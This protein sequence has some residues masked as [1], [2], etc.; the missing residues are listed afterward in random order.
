[1]KINIEKAMYRDEEEPLDENCKCSVCKNYS[2]AFIHHLY[3]T[4][5]PIKERYGSIHNLYFI[6]NLMKNIRK[7]IEKNEFKDFKKEFFNNYK[8]NEKKITKFTYN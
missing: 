5:E 1:G 6:Q 4:H 8:L 3:R 7:S 2:K